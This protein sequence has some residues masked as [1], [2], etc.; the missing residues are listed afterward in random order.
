MTHP[1]KRVG[2]VGAIL[3][4]FWYIFFYADCPI[5]DKLFELCLFMQTVMPHENHDDSSF[6][7]HTQ[8]PDVTILKSF[9][10]YQDSPDIS[11]YSDIPHLL[12]I[13]EI[14]L[15]SISGMFQ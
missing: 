9:L 6:L 1:P 4:G 11:G 14:S 8:S 2:E 3:I 10:G 12:H 15:N 13:E 7:T 5:L